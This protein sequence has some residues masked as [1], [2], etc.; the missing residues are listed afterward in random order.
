MSY[1][2]ENVLG[3]DTRIGEV[4][5][6]LLMLGY[7]RVGVLKS[8]DL[9]TFEQYS[10]FDATDY[11]SWSG[12][13][14]SIH[15]NEDRQV[16]VSTRSVIARSYYDLIHQNNTIASLR[17]R[18]GGTFRTDEGRGRYLRPDSGPP[19]AP[20]SGCHLAF[21]RF[22]SNLIKAAVCHEARYFPNQPSRSR[23]GLP[24][25]LARFLDEIDP[26]TL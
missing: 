15:S 16:C 3:Q 14:L 26:R 7:R 23:K 8:R 18:F 11:R 17:R 22:G 21:E 6:F 10:W 20:A 2:S 12:V 5:E 9:G 19:S 1:S 4:R 24:R 25:D 13:E